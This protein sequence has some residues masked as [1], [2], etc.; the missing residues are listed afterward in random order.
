MMC[1]YVLWIQKEN[2]TGFWG[3]LNDPLKG[4]WS[5]CALLVFI[6]QFSVLGTI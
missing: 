4:D 2:G 5:W 3:H 1:V 6:E